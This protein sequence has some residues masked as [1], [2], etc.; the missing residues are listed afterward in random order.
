MNHFLLAFVLLASGYKDGTVLFFENTQPIVEYHTRSKLTHAAIVINIDNEPWVYEAW[1][2]AVRK[3]KLVDYLEEIDK[4]NLKPNHFGD[5]KIKVWATPPQEDYSA[6]EIAAMKKYLDSQLGREYSILSYLQGP[7]HTIHCCELVTNAM[8]AT[9]RF[10]FQ[11][12]WRV[13]PVDL[14]KKTNPLKVMVK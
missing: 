2:P 5:N 14:W 10:N 1:R 9:K 4:K 6:E 12:P 7:R 13:T 11:Q 3:I 8:N